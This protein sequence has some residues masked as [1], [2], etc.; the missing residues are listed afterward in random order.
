AAKTTEAFNLLVQVEKNRNQTRL[1]CEALLRHELF[2][3][4]PIKV[5]A[6]GEQEQTLAGLHRIN[7]EKLN[8]LSAE[9]LFELRNASALQIAYCQLL[10]MQHIQRMGKLAGAHAAG[11][12][13]AQQ[14]TEEASIAQNHGTI[15]FE[16]LR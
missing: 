12:K 14:F 10:S 4:W 11:K 15:S 5:L 9:A 3:P 13:A 16:N 7:E 2:E 6:E 1:A 8:S